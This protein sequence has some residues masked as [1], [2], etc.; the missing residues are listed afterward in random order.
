MKFGELT[1]VLIFNNL[2]FHRS[3]KDNVSGPSH[4][5]KLWMT[6]KRGFGLRLTHWFDFA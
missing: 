4:G 6:S 3:A 2:P 5:K 1:E